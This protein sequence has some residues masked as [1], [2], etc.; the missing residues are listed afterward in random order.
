MAQ[1]MQ[2]HSDIDLIKIDALK[3]EGFLKGCDEMFQGNN[4]TIIET[5]HTT[6]FH[7]D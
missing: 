4:V 5:D 6:Y 1:D 7:E 3:L 2:V